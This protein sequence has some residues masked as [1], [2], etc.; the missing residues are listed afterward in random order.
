M[1]SRYNSYDSRSSTSS[2]FSDPS[3][4]TELSYKH[5]TSRAIV[6]SK[7]AYLSKIKVKN[8]G[9]DHNLSTMV[10][11]LMEKKSVSSTSSKGSSSKCA[12]LVIPSDLIAED[13]KKTAGKGT[14]FMGL[15]RKLFGKENKKEMKGVKALTEAKVNEF[16]QRTLAMVLKSERELLSANKEKELEI[17]KLKLM[18]EVKNKEVSGVQ[19][20]KLKDLCLKQ[21][22]E[23]RSL[24]NSIL[25]PD[26][27][28][29][30][31]QELLEQQG[32]ELNQAKQLIPTLQRQVTSLTGQLQYLADDLAEVKADNYPRAC[33]HYPGSSPGTPS[34]DHEETANSLLFVFDKLSI[35]IQEFSS[36]DGATPGSLDDMLL[37]DL[38]PCLT[39]YCAEKKSKE[40]EAIGYESSL[41][42]SLFESNT[43]TSNELSF[44]SRLRKLSKSSDCY[45]NSS[46]GS[47]MTRTTRRSEETEGAYRKQAQQTHF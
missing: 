25:F 7:P 38:N 33:I 18:L 11:K 35:T 10:K 1:A 14:G 2:Y 3:S 47:T 9:N 21:R 32:S 4:S 5:L 22:E 37:K 20:E 13:L 12:G 28:N 30:Q 17:H 16:Q 26:T 40:F 43:Q 15:Q 8:N 36:C 6:E 24:K 34:H 45:Q 39:P 19:V 27:M 42:V 29:S 41:D 46:S 31:L 44:S 23:I